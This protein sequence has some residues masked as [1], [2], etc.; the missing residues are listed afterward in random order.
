MVGD[1]HPVGVAAEVMIG[2]PGGLERAFGVDDPLFPSELPD[3]ALELH[4]FFKTGNL[5]LQSA[6]AEGLLQALQKL[7]SDDLRERPD[8][9]Q[10]AVAGGNPP[11]AIFTEPTARY[12]EVQM[13]MGLEFLI[14]RVQYGS[15]TDLSPQALVVPS[16][17]EQ[18]P[19]GGLKEEIEDELL[20]ELGQRI[21]FVGQGDHQVKVAGGQ[22]SF[23]ARFQPP[24]LL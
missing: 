20:V 9:E 5:P 22:E 3:E 16:K 6:L 13:V 2:I 7:A 15:K 24:G 21:E 8:G 23:Q 1:G 14:P 4:R 17:L 19:G 10:E 11:L 12:Y 18:G